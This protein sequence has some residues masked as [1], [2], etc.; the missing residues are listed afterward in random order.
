MS[1]LA[2]CRTARALR[3][4]VRL[5]VF[6]C[7]LAAG[8]A[9]AQP[10]TR[11]S[12]ATT[13]AQADK[14]CLAPG[15]SAD[16]R[17]VV[18]SSHAT[19][20]APGGS[21]GMLQIFLHDRV[22]GQ[23]TLISHKKG[24]KAK[25]GDKDS[26]Y[27]SISHDGRYIVFQSLATDLADGDTNGK[28]DIYLYDRTAGAATLISRK[29]GGGA[30]DGASRQPAMSRDAGKISFLSTAK[31]MTDPAFGDAKDQVF[32]FDRSTNKTAAVSI[33]TD[34]KAADAACDTPVISHDG[35]FV[36]FSSAATNLAA[37]DTNAKSDIFRRDLTANTTALVSKDKDGNPSDGDSLY[38]SI[39][40]DGSKIA[41]E[42]AATDLV[43][44]DT[45]AKNDVFLRDVGAGTNTLVSARAGDHKVGNGASA[46]PSI[47]LDGKFVAF[48]S[49][50]TDLTD[51]PTTVLSH[52]FVRDIA[53]KSNRV[54]SVAGD[55]SLGSHDSERPDLSGDGAFV[56]FRTPS[57]NLVGARD[58]GGPKDDN[59]LADVFVHDI[60]DDKDGLPN[61]WEIATID[62]DYNGTGD[63]DLKAKGVKPDH[64][65]LLLEIDSMVDQDP[66]AGPIADVVAA[67]AAA[68][69]ALVQNP[70][71]LDGI[72][73]IA[74]HDHKDVANAAWD[75]SEA[76][77]WTGF[78]AVKAAK[79]GTQTEIES[80][81]KAAILRA[82]AR[83]YRYCIIGQ[84]IRGNGTS[85]MAELPGNDCMVTLGRKRADGTHLWERT[86]GQWAGTIM[87]EFGHTL[88]LRHGGGDD[89]NQKPNYHSIMSY[90]W[91]MPTKAD[92]FGADPNKA[93]FSASRRLDYSRR[94]FHTL[95]EDELIEPAGVGGDAGNWVPVGP[96]LSAGA[97]AGKIGKIVPE[98][99]RVDF[100]RNGKIEK[101]TEKVS[102]NLNRPWDGAYSAGDTEKLEGHEDWSAIR[103]A[104]YGQTFDGATN[105]RYYE[106]GVDR[107]EW[108]FVCLGEEEHNLI[109]HVGW[110][111]ADFNADLELNTIDVTDFLNAY[112]LQYVAA[113]F[114]ADGVVDSRDT[115]AFLDAWAAGCEH[116]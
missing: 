48:A 110:C 54:C 95:K 38:P 114:N 49:R 47:S 26:R 99:G 28:S 35:K 83:V 42:S 79:F 72:K 93:K 53:A 102:A 62:I 34:N 67:F 32:V 109:D 40:R 12:V 23:T 98:R 3:M 4:A 61:I 77:A 45:N 86:R 90:T 80:G 21:G 10:T 112:T 101:D 89:T 41:F 91:Q 97:G 60:D 56:A 11:V 55:D 19:T 116:P 103:Y 88:G 29:N 36:A 66:G 14:P 104:V 2:E 71:G 50:A 92:L 30:A 82:K 27:P 1:L 13:G 107:G 43:A 115:I 5:V 111:L 113:D 73:L 31:N 17:F 57:N 63:L 22:A 58:S 85:G 78:D 46:T 39:A 70:D 37:G 74:E 52:V 108:T 44:D 51:P 18:F 69:N 65:D 64:K 24:D 106:D 16:G 87:H 100:N 9:V 15:I 105:R 20:L 94:K 8:P 75:S 76:D 81:N 59:A 68:P 7:T 84:Q 6:A 96:L 25:P 33:G